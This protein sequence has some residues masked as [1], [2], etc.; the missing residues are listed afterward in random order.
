[1]I[2]IHYT[3]AELDVMARNYYDQ[4]EL[5][6]DLS[7]NLRDWPAASELKPMMTDLHQHIR[8]IISGQPAQLELHIA[9]LDALG[10]DAK[11]A[12]QLHYAGTTPAEAEKWYKAQ[13]FSVFDYD[14]TA[15]GFTRREDGQMAYGHAMALAVNTCPYCNTQFTYT[16]KSKRSKSRP[17]FDHYLGKAK[18]PYFALSFY[19]LVP[20]CYP[21]N[22]NLKGRKEFSVHTHLHPFIDDIEGLY[23]FR[24]NISGVD[25]LV[26]NR[27]FTLVIQ[28]CED[29]DDHQLERAKK[30]L[31][32][33]EIQDR[34]RFHKDYAEEILKKAYFYGDSGIEDLFLGYKLKGKSIFTSRNEIRELLIG[35]AM[36]PD[37][38]HKR[39]LSKISRDIA[40]EFGLSLEG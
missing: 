18:H 33:F 16:I 35:N 29:L 32:V 24:T 6:F 34:Y 4:L 27:D 9:R 40:Q 28:P 26:D 11:A 3:L 23:E 31:E 36:H 37:R 8:E 17:H 25:F 14:N 12:Y 1:M 10:E 30:S 5:A 20:S 19:N 15:N 2:K 7:T 38:F 22:S 13:L 21:C 39:V